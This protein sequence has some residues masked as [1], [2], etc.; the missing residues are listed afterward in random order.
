MSVITAGADLQKIANK[1]YAKYN[2]DK[3]EKI[4]LALE[5]SRIPY[6]AR[7]NNAEISL[8]YDADYKQ[9]V[10][11][12]I[13]KIMS[14][15]YNEIV[16]ELKRMTNINGYKS[17]IPEIAEMLDTSVSFLKSRPD[18][19][20]EIVCKR[21]VDLWYCDTPTIKRE[22]AEILNLGNCAEHY[23]SAEVQRKRVEKIRDSHIQREIREHFERE[24][25][26]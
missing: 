7:F 6:F 12:I 24:R 26:F 5:K 2:T 22:L 20:Q 10:E 23:V 14:G 11:E 16:A 9:N 17:L 1:T 18:E 21:Y 19:V 8:T 25:R 15:A 13:K 3:G 4:A